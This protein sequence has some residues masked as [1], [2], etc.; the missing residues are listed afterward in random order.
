LSDDARI[1]RLR[2]KAPFVLA[3]ASGWP[4]NGR[5]RAVVS[6]PL[7]PRGLAM[8]PAQFVRIADMAA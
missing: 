8:S 6:I 1:V 5:Q 7:R 3:R 4:A 2:H